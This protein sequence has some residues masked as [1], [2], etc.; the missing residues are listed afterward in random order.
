MSA[1][2]RHLAGARYG[3]VAWGSSVAAAECAELDEVLESARRG[4]SRTLVV[5][6]EPGIGK[7]ALID[8]AIG[9]AN[10]FLV[11][12]F[13]G[14]ESESELGYA[15]L[16]RLL[17]PVLHQVQRLPEPQR[18]AM[19]SALGLAAGPP[20]NPF[21]VGLGTMS[22]AANAAR[23]ANRLLCVIDDSQWVDRES[24]SALA[25]WGRRIHA[26]GIALVICD[27]DVSKTARLLEGFD[28]L[29][30]SGLD[31][32]DGRELLGARSGAPVDAEVAKRIVAETGGNALA[33][34]ELAKAL[35]DDQLAGLVPLDAP[36]PLAHRLEEHFVRQVRALPPIH[37][38]TC[39]SRRRIRRA[40]P[41]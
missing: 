11:V 1:A 32:A 16:H 18:D 2:R 26:E 21:L 36:L 39:L 22:I 6:G 12:R 15:A 41:R 33:L 40:A 17:T 35:S 24:L 8:Y 13:T 14:I 3:L 27:R 31:D 10:D 4:L 7:T 34:V 25:F 28:V 38:C 20:S 23:A 19:S 5:R 37:R 9:R 30:V 29:E